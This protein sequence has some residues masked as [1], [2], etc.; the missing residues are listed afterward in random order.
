MTDQDFR[1]KN[2]GI[3]G[4]PRNKMAAET[5]L[6][7]RALLQ[8]H[9]MKLFV[10]ES[11]AKSLNLPEEE[12][13]SKEAMLDQI[14]LA[15]VVGG[16]GSMLN[17][18]RILAHSD[19]PVVG[20]NRGHLGFLTDIGPSEIEEKL[21]P[22]LRGQYHEER[23]FLLQA[24]A[25]RHDD[26]VGRNTALNEVVLYPGEISRMLEFDIYVDGTFVSSQRSD[27]LIVSTPTGS[28]AYSLSGGGPILHPSLDAVVLVPMFPQTLS[29]RP[30]VI[31][32]DSIIQL[33]ISASNQ[34]A[35]QLSFDGQVRI[36]LSPGDIIHIEKQKQTLR[37]LHP[38][39]QDYYHVLRTKLNWAERLV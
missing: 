32:A 2:I 16:D 39:D 31:G 29:G 27:G 35:P 14:E 36:P 4:K 38:L 30:I 15:I 8:Q 5:I 33:N 20:I 24:S 12:H 23:R 21:L 19:I 3:W 18:G 17:A 25:M 26:V 28:T 9:G 37:M 7:L 1:F 22:I 34:H 10:Q 13:Y 6:V 11:V